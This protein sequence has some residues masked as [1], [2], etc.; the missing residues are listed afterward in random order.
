[1]SDHQQLDLPDFLSALADVETGNGLH[2]NASEY[3]K[4]AAEARKLSSDLDD[5]LHRANTLA[6]AAHNRTRNA[7][8]A[9]EQLSR[10][11]PDAESVGEYE[12]VRMTLSA[13]GDVRF[14]PSAWAD[15]IESYGRDPRQMPMP[16]DRYYVPVEVAAAAYK[17]NGLS[18]TYR[19][20]IRNAAGALESGELCFCVI[21]CPTWPHGAIGIVPSPKLALN[22]AA[23]DVPAPL[24]EAA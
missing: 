8:H 19:P 24:S 17:E 7:A 4:R 5:A 16:G 11:R 12:Q 20:M 1:M 13:I 2:I 6:L 3:S 21:G 9:Y 18:I 22:S 14:G 23:L 15:Q 10:V